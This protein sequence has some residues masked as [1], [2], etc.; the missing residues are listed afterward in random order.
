M[1]ISA[2]NISSLLCPLSP[3]YSHFCLQLQ[4]VWIK[5]N[6]AHIFPVYTFTIFTRNSNQSFTSSI[7]SL[8]VIAKRR[9][10]I[11]FCSRTIPQTYFLKYTCDC[12]FP[13]NFAS[14]HCKIQYKSSIQWGRSNLIWISHHLI[15]NPNSSL[16]ANELEANL[17]FIFWVLHHLIAKLCTSLR[18]SEFGATF[19]SISHHLIAK[20]S[21]S[22]R[23]NMLRAI[24]FLF[25]ESSIIS[26]QNSLQASVPVSSEQT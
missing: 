5:G 21:T 12:I 24:L 10:K 11:S 26:L 8:L 13:L 25:V 17:V 4:N 22:L 16:R 15:A 20:S 18:S 3:Y 1:R 2:Q 23:A 7:S 9:L 6:C 19:S 14:S